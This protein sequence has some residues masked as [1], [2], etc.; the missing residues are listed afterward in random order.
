MPVATRIVFPWIDSHL[1][2][3]A[4]SFSRLHYQTQ[5]HHSRQGS[6]GRGTNPSQKPLPH[7]TQKSQE[8]LLPTCEIRTRSLSKIAAA[9]PR[10]RPS[11][12][13]EHLP[14][15]YEGLIS[16][17][18]RVVINFSHFYKSFVETGYLMHQISY[19]QGGQTYFN[20]RRRFLFWPQSPGRFW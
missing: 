6:P 19:L 4:S 12:H 18:D 3:R 8:T 1:W 17:K 9:D 10:L 7:N 2:A 11:G 20:C 14:L 13:W 15:E 5:T 16:N